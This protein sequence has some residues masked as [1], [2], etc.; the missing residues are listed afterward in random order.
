MKLKLR[1]TGEE[2]DCPSGIGRALLAIKDSPVEVVPPPP[3][4]IL[5]QSLAWEVIRMTQSGEVVIVATCTNCHTQSTIF[6]F[7]GDPTSK[8]AIHTCCA[9]SVYPRDVPIEIQRKYFEQRGEVPQKAAQGLQDW[10]KQR[11][12]QKEHERETVQYMPSTPT[13]F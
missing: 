13:T 1:T 8:K 3:K 9:K 5:F 6:N 12:A 10:L 11:A 2:F 7:S 4:P